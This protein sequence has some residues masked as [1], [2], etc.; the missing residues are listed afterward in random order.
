MFLPRT[1]CARAPPRHLRFALASAR[2]ARPGAGARYL[3]LLPKLSGVRE[4]DLGLS[5]RIPVAVMA[6]SS[7]TCSFRRG[8]GLHAEKSMLPPRSSWT[9]APLSPPTS[10]AIPTSAT[11]E[12]S[13]WTPAQRSDAKLFPLSSP[14]GYGMGQTGAPSLQ[15]QSFH[16]SYSC[17][18]TA[19]VCRSLLP[20]RFP[21]ETSAAL[22]PVIRDAYGDLAVCVSIYMF[23]TRSEPTHTPG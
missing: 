22:G 13:A 23:P 20:P 11:G 9:P 14:T 12:A 17:S 19:G 8:A 2:P 5:K 21:R 1:R 6:S 18:A 15:W 3:H 4:P 16:D 7:C 10:P